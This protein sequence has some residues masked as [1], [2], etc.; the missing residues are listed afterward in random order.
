MDTK[1]ALLDSAEKASRM[2]GYDGFSYADLSKD[3]GIRKASIHHHFPTKADLAQALLRR[4]SQRF[5]EALSAIAADH[6]KGGARLKA[7]VKAYRES[8]S[9]GEMVCLCVAFSA[10]RD[11]LS[12]P[13]LSELN[14]FG[15][16]SATWLTEAF[17]LGKEDASILSVTDPR[18]E[19]VA[20]LALVEGAQ[21]L[22][23][24]ARDVS[25]FDAAVA[26]LAQR[27]G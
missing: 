27:F 22:A 7:Y 17:R 1:T 4:Y 9:G 16:R 15:D 10:G 12:D 6:S 18:S 13:V 8:L 3:V 24:A 21:L 19:A 23:R 26:I 2:R 25:R 14:T 20:C 11:S 5:F